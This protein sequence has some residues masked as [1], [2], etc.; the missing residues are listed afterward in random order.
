MNHPT[1]AH[2]ET[3]SGAELDKLLV[4]ECPRCHAMEWWTKEEAASHGL[5]RHSGNYCFLC[6][7]GDVLKGVGLVAVMAI[8]PRV[9]L[10][11]GARKPVLVSARTR[12][13]LA[14]MD[15]KVLDA[16]LGGA[17]HG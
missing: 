17:R 7:E 3:L 1:I 16:A 9:K 2:P 13:A 6:N 10:E 12:R 4:V 11:C 5:C 14:S 15:R 8:H